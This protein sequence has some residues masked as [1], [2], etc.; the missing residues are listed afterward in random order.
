MTKNMMKA[1]THVM[2][3]PTIVPVVTVENKSGEK[4]NVLTKK[5]R[6]IMRL[7]IKKTY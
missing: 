7:R 5:M 3:I 4:R 2:Q 6:K 1:V